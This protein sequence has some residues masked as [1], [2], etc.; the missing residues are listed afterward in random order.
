MSPLWGLGELVYRYAIHISPL[1]GFV[2]WTR[3]PPTVLIQ[4][5]SA[6]WRNAGFFVELSDVRAGKPDAPPTMGLESEVRNTYGVLEHGKVDF[7]RC[8]EFQ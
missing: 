2:S 8:D 5:E 3:C 6:N 1:W 7:L 4:K